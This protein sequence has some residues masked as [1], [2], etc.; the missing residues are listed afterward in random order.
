MTD[1]RTAGHDDASIGRNV[2]IMRGLRGMEAAELATLCGVGYQKALRLEN[3]GVPFDIA[4]LC[5][6]ADILDTTP[7][8]LLDGPITHRMIDLTG[9]PDEQA[10]ALEIMADAVRTP[11]SPQSAR[12]ALD[13]AMRLKDDHGMARVT[14]L[15]KRKRH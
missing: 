1:I 13:S 4:L 11:E 8:R 5:R 7:G 15:L 12:K 3:G 6:I 10:A 2:R 14:H 9:I